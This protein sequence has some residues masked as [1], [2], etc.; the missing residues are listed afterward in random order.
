MGT[1][2]Y[3]MIAVAALV[4]LY[5]LSRMLSKPMSP[6]QFKAAVRSRIERKHPDVKI[7]SELDF[8]FGC[9][10]SGHHVDIFLDNCYAMYLRNPGRFNALADDHVANMV[11]TRLVEDVG[12]DEAKRRVFPSLKHKE[13]FEAIQ[14]ADE[15][16]GLLESMVTFDY[17]GNLKT[18]IVLDFDRV[19]RS[20][21]KRDLERW[22]VSG[23][24]V[25]RC[26]LSNLASRTAPLWEPVCDAS[27]KSG[28]F[29]F[30]SCDGYDASR[31]LLPDFCER[32]SQALGA[33]KIV[34]AIP[35]RDALLAVSAGYVKAT[36]QL[37]QMAQEIYAKGD[38][39]VSPDVFF[40]PK[41]A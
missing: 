26:A 35:I 22:R 39:S 14:Q 12:W 30:T 38:H 29:K 40:F 27:K 25:M 37:R 24:E 21:G 18:V 10:A 19:M 5:V 13:Y 41:E 31:M 7:E 23:D 11:E 34:V 15:G 17:E 32:V 16:A 2:V 28:L 4:V 3:L 1:S 6:E 8:G 20:V 36:E 33:D 9:D